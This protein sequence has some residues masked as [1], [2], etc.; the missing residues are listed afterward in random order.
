PLRGVAG[1]LRCTLRRVAGLLQC[2][3][4]RVAGLLRTLW[5]MTRGR[6]LAIRTRRPLRDTGRRSA[7]PGTRRWL[8]PGRRGQA[9]DL[10]RRRTGSDLRELGLAFVDDV[11]ALD[12]LTNHEVQ[13]H[14]DAGHEG[15]RRGL[16]DP[17]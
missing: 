7:G 1:L 10:D 17:A 12:A 14:R 13:A 15:H 9:G 2:T 8:L 6:R 3:L 5:R 4:R 16:D 11:I